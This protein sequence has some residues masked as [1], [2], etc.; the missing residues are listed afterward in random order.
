MWIL[1]WKEFIANSSKYSSSVN[2][3]T[4]ECKQ[5]SLVLSKSNDC[6]TNSSFDLRRLGRG[7]ERVS[8]GPSINHRLPSR[9]CV[10]SVFEPVNK[11]FSFLI[12]TWSLSNIQYPFMIIKQCRFGFAIASFSRKQLMICAAMFS[13]EIPISN[14]EPQLAEASAKNGIPNN[15]FVTGKPLALSKEDLPHRSRECFAVL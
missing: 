8:F 10:C 2:F 6:K 13:W 4:S 1:S 5:R 12:A 3:P 11:D 14:I 9:T 7:R 15:I